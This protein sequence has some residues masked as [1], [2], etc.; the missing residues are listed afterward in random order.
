MAKTTQVDRALAAIDSDIAKLQ[1]AR[2][3]LVS[4]AA[5]APEPKARKP[6]TVKS[7]PAP[8]AAK[9]AGQ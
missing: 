2:A 4:A 7:K 1:T 5:S 8:E 9:Q 6:R 3:I